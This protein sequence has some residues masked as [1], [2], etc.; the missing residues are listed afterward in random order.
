MGKAVRKKSG[1]K[2]QIKLVK[3]PK[4]NSEKG[5]VPSK[6]K[7]K[8]HSDDT[9]KLKATIKELKAEVKK[10]DR[11]MGEIEGRYAEEISLLR[12][13]VTDLSIE[14]QRLKSA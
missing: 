14:N 10:R 1:V 9:V 2:T 13:L 11:K 4:E 5:S 8:G 7:T 12:S 6:L 3:R